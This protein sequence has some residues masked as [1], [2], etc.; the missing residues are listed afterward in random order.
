V[1][2]PEPDLKVEK[3]STLRELETIRHDWNRLLKDSDIQTV[4]MTFEWQTTYWKYFNCDSRL[5]VLVVR[6][7]GNII[8]VLP[9]KISLMRKYLFKLRKME[10]LA[11]D[12]NNYQSFIIGSRSKEVLDCVSDYLVC[13]K[14]KWDLLKLK[15][16]PENTVTADYFIKV[17]NKDLI[18]QVFDKIKCIFMVMDSTWEEF[19]KNSKSDRRKV[20]KN[21]RRLKKFGDVNCIPYNE[22]DELV[23]LNDLFELHRK[24][25]NAT[26]TPSQF[27]QAAKR[28]FYREVTPLLNKKGQVQFFLLTVN[29][30]PAAIAY[31]FIYRE[32]I[33]GQL[34]TF[35]PDFS[36]GS[37]T[38]AMLE[39]SLE[40]LFNK[41]YLLFDFGPYYPYKK[42][43]GNQY[44]NK[45]TLHIYP[46][47][48]L[49]M[50]VYCLSVIKIK[51]STN[52]STA[53]RP[54]KRTLKWFFSGLVR[55]TLQKPE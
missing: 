19:R 4:E 3:I 17:S 52:L 12:E 21:I 35:D 27:N 47:R 40:Q 29:E 51:A 39:L 55:I 28:N 10:F 5:F 41:K 11:E 37:P 49:P 54:F 2:S 9:L 38:I 33:T 1:L 20:A 26:E 6:E 16:I 22:K 23:L 18:C 24:R 13:H 7:R 15:N 32:K 31:Y 30:K 14:K 46:K 44:K 8:A 36:E 42:L 45:Y 50:A 53:L 34:I 43:W 25:W 48:I